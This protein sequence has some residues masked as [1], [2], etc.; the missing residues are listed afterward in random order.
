MELSKR[1]ALH[2]Q[3][4]AAIAAGGV[5]GYLIGPDA[6]L[7]GMQWVDAFD[8]LGM[9]F[10][11]A[12]K[13]LVVPLVM[14]SV[15]SGIAS[16]RSAQD[17]GRLGGMTLLFYVVTTLIAILV[18]VVIAN[19]VEPGIVEGR[20][21]HDLLAFEVDRQAVVPAVRGGAG[22]LLETLLSIVPANVVAAATDNKLLGLVFF[23][24][25]LGYC[26]SRL[27][28]Q[29][30]APLL[31][32]FNSLFHV[33]MRMT[34]LV[35][36]LA[37]VGVFGLA[38][39]TV[40]KTGLDAVGPLL[41]FSASVL[42][43][44][45]VYAVILLPALV[46]LVARVR[47]WPLFAAMAPALLTAFST[48][49]SSGTLAISMRCVEDRLG[50]SNRVC[51]FVMPLG[52]SLNHAGSALY[53]CAAVMF[54][55]QA[56]GLELSFSHQLTILVLALITS[57]GIAGIPAASLVGIS[58]ILTAVGLPA[59]AIGVLLVFDRPL[60]MCRTAVNVFADACCAVIVARLEGET[61][62][63]RPAA[64]YLR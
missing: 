50:V 47:V 62:I 53:E 32:F 56:Y 20:P 55:A 12:L 5:L 34:G 14:S 45:F 17:L 42:G 15:V 57:M 64:E 30:S 29:Q 27:E 31:G 37:P 63:P 43:G 38:A 7:F 51:G 24:I 28:S 6:R 21:A 16:L 36:R 59:E 60:D 22:S 48:A 49:S 3:I 52:T 61:G 11:S 44:L 10:V 58:I 4:L 26:L 19:V 35:M 40:A 54:I 8:V 41:T 25:L 9:L 1:V 33:M 2:W 23:S 18:A 39:H 46:R 13:M